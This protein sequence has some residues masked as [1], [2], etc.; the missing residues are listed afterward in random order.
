LFERKTGSVKLPHF[1]FKNMTYEALY[2]P[3]IYKWNKTTFS[4]GRIIKF[5]GQVVWIVTPC[6]FVVLEYFFHVL[7][8]FAG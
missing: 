5:Y 7:A 4:N 1:K 3:K 8:P 6:G 2:I